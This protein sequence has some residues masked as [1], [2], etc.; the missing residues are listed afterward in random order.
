M[1]V[2]ERTLALPDPSNSRKW[3]FIRSDMVF[4]INKFNSSL[5]LSD[6]VFNIKSLIHLFIERET[7]REA[8]LYHICENCKTTFDTVIFYLVILSWYRLVLHQR[9]QGSGPLLPVQLRYK[10]GAQGT[11]PFRFPPNVKDRNC[12]YIYRKNIGYVHRITDH[13]MQIFMK[14]LTRMSKP[15]LKC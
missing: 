10:G 12:E 4:N 1:S 15:F 3:G 9:V 6:M 8:Y 13:Q 2:G 11:A 14:A 5:E 7:E